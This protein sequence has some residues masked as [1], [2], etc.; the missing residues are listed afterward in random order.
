MTPRRDQ[1]AVE[2]G[3][4]VIVTEAQLQR[5]AAA[6][7]GVEDREAPER[8]VGVDRVDALEAAGPRRGRQAAGQ[9]RPDVAGATPAASA[10]SRA[11]PGEQ[12]GRQ[13]LVAEDRARLHRA[14]GVAADRPVGGPELDPRQLGGPCGQRLEA[15][16]EARRDRPADVRPVGRDA[17]ERRRRP[18]VDDDCRRAVKPLRRRAR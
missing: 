6:D 11:D 14:H 13:C 3:R 2:R 15:Q 16:L 12:A 5:L 10:S 7:L 18:E 1:P 8:Q 17:V 4:R 9:D